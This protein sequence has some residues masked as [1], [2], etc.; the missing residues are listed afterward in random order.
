MPKTIRGDALISLI[1][2]CLGT[3][4]IITSGENIGVVRATGVRSRYVTATSGV[5]LILL[6]LFAPLGRLINA[7][8]GPV[9]GGTAVIVFC[10]IAVMGI[11]QLRK[12]DLHDHGN[13]FTLAAGL[14]M[15]L[16]PILVMA[17]TAAYG[18]RRL[19]AEIA[20]GTVISRAEFSERSDVR[21]SELSV[22]AVGGVNRA[23]AQAR[24]ITGAYFDRLH[25][26]VTIALTLAVVPLL[27]MNHLPVRFAWAE[28]SETYWMT[29]AFQGA[30]AAIVLYLI[31]FSL[32][33]TVG[34][35]VGRLRSDKRRILIL[36]PFL[37]I[38]YGLT[39]VLATAAVWPF[40]AVFSLAILEWFDRSQ[41]QQDGLAS[42]IAALAPA[43]IY[44]FW[45]LIL[46][47]AYNDIAVASRPNVTYDV[48]FNR[49][50][51]W[52]M[53]GMTVSGIAHGALHN[54]PAWFYKAVEFVYYFC[55]FPQIGAAMLLLAF[56][57]GRREAF[58]LS[59]ALLTAYYL[60]IGIFWIWPTQGPFFLC[61]TH[62]TDFRSIVLT[63]PIQEG[64]LEKAAS[65][66]AGHGVGVVGLD[67]YI[68]F[69]SMHVAIPAIVAVFLRRWR[70]VFY[71]LLAVDVLILATVI[72]LEWHYV[73]DVVGGVALAALVTVLVH[74]R[75][76]GSRRGTVEQ[77]LAVT[78]SSA[79]LA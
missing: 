30:V 8:P 33:E 54:L 52:L 14:T 2:A 79:A 37:L 73:L 64:L 72:L 24:G 45:G 32:K 47:S 17:R 77:G 40:L 18:L 4:L 25:V 70:R 69:P 71:T 36:I 78:N 56:R 1:G 46:V 3:S 53:H 76:G 31:G 16:L 55:M 61:S 57:S 38:L 66:W 6:A 34:P 22:G 65:L 29:F 60:A 68:A 44:L 67:Y 23:P 42:P 7:I 58:R 12:V 63:Y 41:G 49:V 9:V 20:T 21:M 26:L 13:L 11:D 5:I 74:P 28:I 51:S 15:G 50:D 19:G 48:A 10:I 39:V 27:R 59:I 35:I 75:L 62:F 43:A